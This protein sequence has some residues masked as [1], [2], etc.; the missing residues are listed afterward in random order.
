MTS[1]GVAIMVKNES[2]RIHVSLNSIK[3]F[4]HKLIILDT[5]S[6]DNTIDIIKKFCRENNIPLFITEKTFNLPY[7]GEQQYNEDGT[8]KTYFH[9]SNSR[10]HMLEFADD[11]VDFLLLLDC[12]DEI[13]NGNNLLNFIEEEKN[14]NTVGYYMTQK[15][16]NGMSHDTY[17]NIRLIKTKNNW[18]YHSPIHEWIGCED[19]IKKKFPYRQVPDVIIYQDRTQDDDKSPKRYLKDELVF[20]S[21]IIRE[22]RERG[23]TDSRTLFYYGQTCLCL[24]K[25]EKA[26][27]IYRERCDVEGYTEETFHS[28]MRCGDLTNRM[29]HEWEE[30]LLWYLKS[31]EY[32]CKNFINPR[33]EPLYKIVEYYFNLFLKT[34]SKEHWEMGYIYALRMINLIFPYECSLFVDSRI[35][36]YKRWN[37]LANMCARRK[38]THIREIGLQSVVKALKTENNVEDLKILQT[39]TDD[40][41]IEEKLKLVR[42]NKVEQPFTLKIYIE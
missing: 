16:W 7:E 22:T 32:S 10:N 25:H 30:S 29:G 36:E 35:Y 6:T 31:Y 14:T 37:L 18:K 15:W 9:F 26:Y 42:E 38:E 24:G 20:E 23:K 3:N 1:L 8:I 12:N 5:G 11:K 40:K 13:Q 33:L 17:L 4:C 28:Y 41:D 34:N 2:K 21:E 19:P 27:K 39:L